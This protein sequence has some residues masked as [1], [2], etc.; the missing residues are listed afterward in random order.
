MVGYSGTPLVKKLGIKPSHQVARLAAP[1][2]FDSL[3]TPLPQDVV[4]HSALD[5]PAFDVIVQFVERRAD[6]EAQFPNLL[7]HLTP[8]GG[9]WI[10]WPKKASKRPTDLT[11]DVIR[12]IALDA[13][14]VDNKV[15]AVDAVW[16]GLRLVF[17]KAD[18]PRK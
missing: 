3:I 18:R 6:L 16:S 15:C 9:L 2:D 5:L 10:A 1:P 14:V 11:E 7:A 12:E 13:G 8:A 4:L 17:R